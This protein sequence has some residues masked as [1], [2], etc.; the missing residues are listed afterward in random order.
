MK[1]M[2]TNPNCLDCL[3]FKSPSY[4]FTSYMET[5]RNHLDVYIGVEFR[6]SDLLALNSCDCLKYQGLKGV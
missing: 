1:G 6:A 2:S 4:F 5:S 3:K